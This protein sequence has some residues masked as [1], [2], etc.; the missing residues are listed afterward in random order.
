MTWPPSPTTSAT[1]APPFIWNEEERRHL[2]AR[3]DEAAFSHYRTKELVLAYYNA[4]AAGD[5][6]VVAA[7]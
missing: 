7:G 6:K 5:T 4:L 3:L 1:T 2:H